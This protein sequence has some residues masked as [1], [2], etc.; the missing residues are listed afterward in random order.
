MEHMFF[1]R[2][3][4]FNLVEGKAK[5]ILYNKFSIT[6]KTSRKETTGETQV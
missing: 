6:V 4:Y 5:V 3:N 1:K 2:Y